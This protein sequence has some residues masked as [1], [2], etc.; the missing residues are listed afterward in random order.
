V[1][2]RSIRECSRSEFVW[3]PGRL[4]SRAG[5]RSIAAASAAQPCPAPRLGCGRAVEVRVCTNRTCANREVLGSC[6]RGTRAAVGQRTW[7]PEVASDAAAPGPTSRHPSPEARRYSAAWSRGA[8][9]SARSRR[10]A[11]P[12]LPTSRCCASAVS[13]SPWMCSCVRRVLDDNQ[14]LGF[15][16]V[17][18]AAVARVVGWPCLR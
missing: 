8:A 16:L 4:G 2:A 9:S 10:R 13:G 12:C 1:T 5:R 17:L 15:A 6:A 14:L 11:T 3:S 7:V 18:L